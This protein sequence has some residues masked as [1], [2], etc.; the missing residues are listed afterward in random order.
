MKLHELLESA[1]NDLS[2][3]RKKADEWVEEAGLNDHIDA[4]FEG[5][6]IDSFMLRNFSN[7][8]GFKKA[9]HKVWQFS[10]RMK[11]PKGGVNSLVPSEEDGESPM[12]KKLRDRLEKRFVET[13]QSFAKLVERAKADGGELVALKT[14]TDP[15]GVGAQKHEPKELKKALTENLPRATLIELYIAVPVSV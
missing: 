7:A 1:P 13:V 6:M 9:D 4:R 15:H 10:F 11:P 8:E 14:S 3:F 5:T 12:V 2:V